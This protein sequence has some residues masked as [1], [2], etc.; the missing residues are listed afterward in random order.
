MKKA[1]SA[2][3]YSQKLNILD[4]F[5][6]SSVLTIL[7][8]RIFLEITGYPQIGNGNLHVAHMLWGG[9]ALTGVGLYLLLSEQPH[10]YLSALV[11]GVGFGFFIDEVGK[12][13]TSDNNY[14]F[15]PSAFLIYI[16]ILSIWIGV[17][18]AVIKVYGGS[19]LSPAE[20]PVRRSLRL[21]IIVYIL[22]QIISGFIAAIVLIF[23]GADLL[24]ITRSL[25]DF[26]FATT[27]TLCIIYCIGIWH[28]YRGRLLLSANT[29]RIGG[30]LSTVAVY[31]FTFYEHQFTAAIG[32]LVTV[33]MII[34][35]S[36][37]SIKSL[38][39]SLLRFKQ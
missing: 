9:L 36:E 12:F 8:I 14:F 17:R 11:S 37:A 15:K 19:F 24:G 29:L 31:P 38:F 16:I 1:T 32:C 39:S 6:L 13:V 5:V 20:W 21:A 25:E 2:M 10:R 34:G 3:P 35:L 26:T 18:F 30:L 23:N 4:I 7:G 22:F 33:A 28:Y 27:L